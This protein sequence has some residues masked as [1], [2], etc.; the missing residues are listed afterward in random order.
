M[1]IRIYLD[2]SYVKIRSDSTYQPQM[3]WHL[4]GKRQK[5]SVMRGVITSIAG[6]LYLL[7]P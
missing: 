6:R 2:R 4:S 7:T 1:T 3:V 5:G